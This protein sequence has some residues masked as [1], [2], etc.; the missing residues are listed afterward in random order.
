MR[1]P[2]RAWIRSE[3]DRSPESG[4]STV[5]LSPKTGRGPVDNEGAG[6]TQG[7]LSGS[8]RQTRQAAGASPSIGRRLRQHENLAGIDERGIADL[9]GIGG[10]N[11]GIAKAV[12]IEL[13]ADR[14][15]AVAGH[16]APRVDG[17]DDG[18]RR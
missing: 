16:H 2:T 15:E 11:L 17:P 13:G 18:M 8:W 12:A 5:E 3:I 6:A 7:L 10:I 9:P 1:R 4:S 14:P